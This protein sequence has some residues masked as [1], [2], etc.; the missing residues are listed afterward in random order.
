MKINVGKKERLIRISAGLV[1]IFLGVVWVGVLALVGV[2]VMVTAFIGW[3]PV[4]AT[5]GFST[6]G[7]NEAEVVPD[8]SGPIADPFE[9]MKT[10][11]GILSGL[12]TTFTA[13]PCPIWWK[14]S[15]WATKPIFFTRF[16]DILARFTQ[17]VRA[18]V[19]HNRLA[20]LK[21]VYPYIP[22]TLNRILCHFSRGANWFYEETGQ[23]L[24][25]LETVSLQPS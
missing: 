25:D 18:I 20:N 2:L 12:S 10:K 7:R 17:A 13:R 19:F 5:F 14:P 11:R 9:R 8:T 1:L 15:S 3:C 6:A 24:E 22:D 4:S 23:L 21:K 16:P